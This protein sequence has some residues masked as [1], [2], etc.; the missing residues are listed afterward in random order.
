MLS[1]LF[2]ESL[3]H[4][5]VGP[6]P[7]GAPLPNALHIGRAESRRLLGDPDGPW[8]SLPPAVSPSA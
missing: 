6:V 7:A 5:F 8:P 3:Q 2:T 4:D 1:L